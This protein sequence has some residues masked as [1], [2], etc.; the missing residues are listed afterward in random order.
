[1]FNAYRY[2]NGL[3][4]SQ[5]W[6]KV[7]RVTGLSRMEELIAD[8]RETEFPCVAVEIGNDGGL[9]MTTGLTTK[10]FY[11]FYVV[12]RLENINDMERLDGIFSAAFDMGMAILARMKSDSRDLGD[13]CYGFCP[14]EIS[15]S[16]IVTAG[17]QACGYA[18]NVVINR[19]YE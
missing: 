7:Y 8:V 17:M 2:I 9:D 3:A 5:G 10:G 15:Y 12:D 6:P 11:T 13:P 19:D 14:D 1:M 18:F 4:P 16:R